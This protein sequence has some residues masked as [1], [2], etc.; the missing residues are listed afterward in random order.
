MYRVVEYASKDG[1]NW[2]IV[3]EWLKHE[4][5]LIIPSSEYW[6]LRRGLIEQGYYFWRAETKPI[7]VRE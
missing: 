1:K 5:E 4:C 7:E 6:D 2:I 3:S